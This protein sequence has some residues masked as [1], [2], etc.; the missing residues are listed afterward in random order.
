M[1]TKERSHSDQQPK[2]N[3]SDASVFDALAKAAQEELPG[4]ETFEP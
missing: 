1:K 2:Q 4:A 3:E